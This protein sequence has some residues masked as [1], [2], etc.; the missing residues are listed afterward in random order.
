LFL[1]RAPM[2]PVLEK[3][4]LVF[5][6]KKSVV[7]PLNLL[8][9]CRDF[10]G[11]RHIKHLFAVD[12][13]LRGNDK[14]RNLNSCFSVVICDIRDPMFF[15]FW[16]RLCRTAGSVAKNIFFAIFAPWREEI[17]CVGKAEGQNK[18]IIRACAHSCYSSIRGGIPGT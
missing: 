18:M 8:N 17:I 2:V 6:L 9:F 15:R 4:L 12:S 13:R 3:K 1:P 11:H 7:L 10:Y 16:L 5:T 14:K